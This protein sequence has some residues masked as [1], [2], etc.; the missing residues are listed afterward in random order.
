MAAY[1]KRANRW[2]RRSEKLKK[3]G[4]K[5][6][7]HQQPGGGISGK[8]AQSDGETMKSRAKK[9]YIWRLASSKC[10]GVSMACENIMA[11]VPIN[12]GSCNGFM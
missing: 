11:S 3:S 4:E 12:L 5:R 10:N 9:C 7:R 6:K 8:T 2:R 1:L